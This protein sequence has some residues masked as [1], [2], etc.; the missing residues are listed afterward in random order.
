VT[1]RAAFL[2]GAAV[3]PLVASVIRSLVFSLA[4]FC[5]TWAA[6]AAGA[7]LGNVLA[8]GW[9]AASGAGLSLTIALAFWWFRR[10]RKRAPRSYGA[11][12]RALIA[13]L[14]RRMRETA[15]PRPVHRPVPQ[16]AS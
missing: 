10:R 3:P 12:S 2:I 7:L 6:C 15:T 5:L 9:G 11:K 14:V 8:S 16:G 1:F 4:P 13:A